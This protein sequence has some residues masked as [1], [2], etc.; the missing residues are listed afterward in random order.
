MVGW[1]LFTID[2]VMW[3]SDEAFGIFVHC[4]TYSPL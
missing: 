2:G 1:E 3:M 4:G